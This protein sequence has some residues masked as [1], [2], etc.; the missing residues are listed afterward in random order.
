MATMI[1]CWSN[2]T[3]ASN[4]P[5]AGHIRPGKNRFEDNAY[6]LLLNEGLVVPYEGQDKP[7]VKTVQN[8]SP[9]ANK[10]FRKRFGGKL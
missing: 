1:E 5:K 4:H 10:K 7:K 2:S 3:I 9:Q 6:H 8:K